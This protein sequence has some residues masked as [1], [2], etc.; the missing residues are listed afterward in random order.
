M[1]DVHVLEMRN[2]DKSFNRVPVLR[3]A[4]FELRKGEVHALVGGNG[5]GKSTLMKI[6]TG[7]YSKDGGEIRIDGKPVEIHSAQDSERLGVAMIFQEFSLV[8]TLTVAENIFLSREP[9]RGLFVNDREAVKR[10]RQLLEQLAVDIDPRAVVD[11]LGVGYWQMVEIAK[12]LSKDARILIMDE[13]TS[14]LSEAETRTLFDLVRRLKDRGISI[15]YISHRMAEI[16][17]ICDR[18]TVLKDG[19]TVLTEEC[20]RLTLD[21][22]I[23]AMLGADAGKSFSWVER[24]FERPVEPVLTV[25]HLSYGNRVKDVSFDLYAGE[26]VGLA[27]LMGS[28]RTEI[29]E[30]IFGI[31][32]A[33]GGEV[34]V[35][36]RLIRR[37]RDAIREGVALVPEDRRKQGLVLDHTVRDN[38]MLP[39]LQRLT[40]GWF[41]QDVQG[42]RMADSYIEKL[43]IK[44]EGSGKVVRL[45]SGGNQQKVVLGKWLARDPKV[46]I[47]DEPTIGVDIGAK[48]DIVEIIR[49]LADSGIAV[50][51][52]SSE[53]QELLAV[54]D[55]LL[56]LYN[57]TILRELD[58]RHIESEE[59]LHHAIQ[60]Y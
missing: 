27:G 5:A 54:S 45:L 17:E 24:K 23:E 60:G 35:N 34:R 44:T 3:K 49:A 15:I 42:A 6:L 30:C 58:R 7:V 9:R 38:F 31:R 14:S 16:F 43:R 29:A 40:K 48:S 53:L 51:V 46:L 55:R 33:T 50:L 41:V 12:A 36:G 37:T 1:S 21:Q 26:I 32:R 47:L 57:G 28:G 2:I 25:R 20:A 39:S 10:A 56:V 8:P 59:V 13:P 4:H 18:I 22:V 19:Q 52:I 11:T